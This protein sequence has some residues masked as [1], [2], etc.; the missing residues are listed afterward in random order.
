MCSLLVNDHLN[1]IFICLYSSNIL[2][3]KCNPTSNKAFHNYKRR[4]TPTCVPYKSGRTFAESALF[5]AAFA[6]D[7]A[8][9]TRGLFLAFGSVLAFGGAFA[10]AFDSVLAFGGALAFGSVLTFL[11]LDF[12]SLT[13]GKSMFFSTVFTDDRR[14]FGFGLI[15]ELSVFSRLLTLFSPGSESV[16]TDRFSVGIT[17]DVFGSIFS[18]SVEEGDAELPLELEYL[19]AI[20]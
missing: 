18:P 10:F 12:G 11:C 19:V 9:E 14:A 13:C 17:E 3:L 20:P 16:S 4:G 5:S 6:F 7:G 2:W 8:R 15:S 1:I